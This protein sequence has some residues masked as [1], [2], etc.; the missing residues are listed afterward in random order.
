MKNLK[1]ITLKVHSLLNDYIPHKE[2]SLWVYDYLDIMNA[3][4]AQFPSLN[5]LRCANTNNF[6]DISLVDD[7]IITPQTL[8]FQ[9]KGETVWLLP[10]FS[11]GQTSITDYIGGTTILDFFGLT[12]AD[13]NILDFNMMDR[14]ILDS[15]LAGR[16]DVLTN[17]NYKDNYVFN[18]PQLVS[19]PNQDVPIHL[20]LVR[21]AGQIINSY[22]K[23]S[24]RAT[25]DYTNIGTIDLN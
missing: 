5:K 15:T 22:T 3:C 1:N 20:G 25:P 24:P 10:L 18:S 4:F 17:A 8:N 11:G 19:S 9:V 13:S 7:K 21:V 16:F 6:Q 14:R 23:S 12:M 2:I